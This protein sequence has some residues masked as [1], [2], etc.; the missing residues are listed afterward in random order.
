ML[1]VFDQV[2]AYQT[3][4]LEGIRAVLTPLGIPLIVYCNDPYAH[5]LRAPL[6]RLLAVTEIRGVIS[7]ILD[8]PRSQADLAAAIQRS[9]L[10][11]VHIGSSSEGPWSV[12]GDNASGIHAVMNHLLD[13]LGVRRV[14]LVRGID[15]H[16]DAIERE[17]QV[18]EELAVRGLALPD[19]L[20]ID[21]HFAQ[22]AAYEAMQALL[23]RTRDFEAVVALNDRSAAGVLDALAEA[24][25]RVP[26]DVLVTGFDDD[27]IAQDV[28]PGLTSVSTRWQ[29]QGAEAARLV[30]TAAAGGEPTGHLKLPAALVVR[31]S[32]RQGEAAPEAGAVRRSLSRTDAL[33]LMDRAL[34]VNRALMSCR[35]VDDLLAE[36]A[37]CMSRLGLRRC[38]IV[39][40]DDEAGG[41][42]SVVLSHVDG[43]TTATTKGES[44]DL[45]AILPASLLAHLSESCLMLQPLSVQGS[46]LG[47]VLFE[48]AAPD[49]FVWEQL[50]MDLSRAISTL[51]ENRRHAEALERLVAVRT[52]Q[53]E[54]EVANRTR[55]ER[56]LR[57]VNQDLMRL[58]NLDGL[59]DIAN[60]SA[61]DRY[62]TE[63]CA[64]HV[65]DGQPMSVLLVD[66]DHFKELNDG[67]GHLS[68]DRSLQVLARCLREVLWSP[69]DLAARYGG[70]EFAAILPSTDAYGAAAVALR[71]RKAVESASVADGHRFTVSIGAATVFPDRSSTPSDVVSLADSALYEAKEQGRDRVVS[72]TDWAAPSG[73]R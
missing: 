67:F 47:Y 37:A 6:T 72:R 46:D 13:E 33:V 28:T 21:G 20:V 36:M 70:D 26:E 31:G 61:F 50:R 22:D 55:A 9:G 10:P 7:T 42:G 18:R 5:G 12:G 25:L 1:V 23:A 51:Q 60:R 16:A 43:R 63:Q 2:S 73:L 15:F 64:A 34:A 29:V 54:A 19:D 69:D 68:G 71:L 53:L 49:R 65:E 40:N 30:L 27:S 57:L 11:S 52:A 59:T 48:Q 58:T 56:E 66:V 41:T 3:Q 8:D 35:S 4:L 62:L 45:R 14:A 39:L 38:F 24:G 32:T 44:F 17:T